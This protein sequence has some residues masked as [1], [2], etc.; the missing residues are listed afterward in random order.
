MTTCK[1]AVQPTRVMLGNAV[2]VETV[3]RDRDGDVV[4]PENIRM[5]VAG[6]GALTSD[7]VTMSQDG[8]RAV[9]TFTP[10]EVGVWTYIV[11]TFQGAV[12]AAE[13]RMVVVT[14]PITPASA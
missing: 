13:E 14:A 2:Y 7:I 6:P 4:D 8:D 5:R 11:E 1:P 3:L 9:G 12:T 10:D